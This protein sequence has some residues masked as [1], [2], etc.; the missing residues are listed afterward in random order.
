M[1]RT[2]YL[3]EKIQPF[4]DLFQSGGHTTNFKLWVLPLGI[5]ASSDDSALIT[6]RKKKKNNMTVFKFFNIFSHLHITRLFHSKNHY[7]LSLL[8]SKLLNNTQF[9]QCKYKWNIT[10]LQT[11]TDMVYYYT[12]I[13]SFWFLISFVLVLE[14][15]RFGFWS[16]KY[17]LPHLK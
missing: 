5:K 4:L 17:T 2:P 9:L 13:N 12:C 10:D 7:W 14:R 6:R 16:G 3:V 8:F 11:I 1:L 15:Q